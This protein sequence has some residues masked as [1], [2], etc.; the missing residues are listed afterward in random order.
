MLMPDALSL[1]VLDP[2]APDEADLLAEDDTLRAESVRRG[3]NLDEV[4]D[5]LGLAP[6]RR[7][8]TEQGSADFRLAE[9][10]DRLT[11]AGIRL[12][13]IGGLAGRLYGSTL[14]TGDLD[15]C[16][17]RDRDNLAALAAMLRGFDAEFR[18]LPRFTPPVLSAATF[19]SETDFIF[20][21]CY[22]KF[23]LIGEF[24]GVGRY[25]EASLDAVPAAFGR[26]DVRVLSLPKLILSKRSTG[27]PRDALVAAELEVVALAAQRL[28][29]AT[30]TT[31]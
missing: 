14:T 4:L 1:R 6:T 27:R 2:I 18:R 21:T 29:R 26:W 11:A 25:R 12:V 22:G 17:A 3:V 7:L 13:L 5:R 28:A 31:S 23:D 16:H 15:I 8:A 24:T 20:T 9:L 19:A 10:L 30:R